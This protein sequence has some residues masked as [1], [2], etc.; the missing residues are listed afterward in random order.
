MAGSILLLIVAM[1]SIQ[2]GASLAK[3][4][5]ASVG[6]QG[7]S[8]LRLILA[9]LILMIVW[10]PWRGALGVLEARAVVFYGL[11]LG[12]MNLLF[13]LALQR[14]PLGLTVTFEFVGPLCLAVASSHRRI[15]LVW[16]AMAG[17]GIFLLLWLGRAGGPIDPEGAM[18]AL[19]AGGCWA[20]Y[21]L[22]GQKAGDVL[23]SGRASALGMIVAAILVAPFGVAHA[24]AKLLNPALLPVALGV[25]VLSSALPYS[26]DMVAMKR[27]PTRTF[28]VLM[29]LEPAIA[30][31]SGL[32]LL[33]ERLGPW[34]WAGL[35]CVM[36]ASFG[37]AAT[38]RAG[39]PP[40]Q[41][42][43]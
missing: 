39:A 19:A 15:D 36:A 11:A 28:G 38:A 14:L 21:I 2:T 37:A 5:F 23:H 20:L 9:S 26:L 33:N 10:R 43:D 24:G 3:E 27:L 17:L 13:Y 31:L 1:I 40:V 8:A 22:F 32:I 42:V 34:Q 30:A 7:A 41:V 12:A 6:P 35:V 25:A 18:F 16:V 29:S 4:M